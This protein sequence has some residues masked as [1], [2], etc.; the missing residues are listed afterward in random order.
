MVSGVLDRARP[1]FDIWGETV[2]LANSMRDSAHAN[3]I[4]SNE[5]AFYRLNNQFE[6]KFPDS[7]SA[8]HILLS[9]KRAVNK[10]NEFGRPEEVVQS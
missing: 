2:E 6:F 10:G 8:H 5:A 4:A 1:S 9:S 3:T 7:S